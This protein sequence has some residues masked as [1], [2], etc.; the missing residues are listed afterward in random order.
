MTGN[1]FGEIFRTTTFGESHGPA[2]GCVIE[3]VPA[4]IPLETEEIQAALNR[5]RP[6]Q[7]ALTTQRQESDKVQILSGIFNGQ[8]TGTPI[9][10]LIL[11]EDQ[12]SSD[13]A[14]IADKFRPGHADLPY[15]LKYGNRD[16][17]GGGRASARETAMRVAA[18]VLARKVLGHF[19]QTPFEITAGLIQVGKEKITSWD[20][21]QINKNA[22]FCPDP[23]ALPRFENEIKKARE[24]KD[25]VGAVIEIRALGFPAGLG[26]PVYDR[27][28]ADLAKALMSIN[29]VKGVEIGDGFAAASLTGRQNA[30][31]LF[32]DPTAENGIGFG[33][34]HAGGILGGLSTGQPIIAR[35]AV[36]PTPSVAAELQTVTTD[37]KK[38][39]ISTTGRHDP[40]VGIRAVPVAEAMTACVLADH[41]LRFRAQYA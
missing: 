15:F 9:G 41:L 26:E 13:Y 2:I 23:A 1:G 36:K 28:D 10:L 6:G 25:S 27:L 38:T 30:D 8:T 21:S 29:A 17:R 32:A 11:N 22:L 14:P 20:S 24:N 4:R 33:S 39:T 7:S 34:N 31:E 18:G 16:Y 40:C 5:R 35:I 19:I 12:H 3:G 37:R